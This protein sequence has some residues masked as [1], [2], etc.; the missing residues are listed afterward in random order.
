M[1]T[2]STPPESEP[3]T[4]GL[5]RS[6]ARAAILTGGAAIGAALSRLCLSSLELCLRLAAAV[7][8]AAL[9]WP[10]VDLPFIGRPL[11]AWAASAAV[12][13]RCMSGRV[14]ATGVNE[15]ERPAA[16]LTLFEAQGSPACRKVRECLD[17]LDLDALVYPCP[18]PSNIAY[19]EEMR[20]FMRWIVGGSSGYN[21]AMGGA[22][23]QSR[24]AEAAATAAAAAANGTCASYTVGRKLALPILI[25]GSTTICGAD[26]ICTYLWQMYGQLAKA[27]LNYRI[28]QWLD[29]FAIFRLLPS[30]LRPL[31]RHGLVLSPSVKPEEPLLLWGFE[32]SPFVLRVREALCTLQLP[33]LA[34]HLPLGSVAKRQAFLAQY[35]GLLSAARRAA[36][37]VNGSPLIQVPALLDPNHPEK[38]L[39]LESAAIVRYLYD[40]YGEYAAGAKRRG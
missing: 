16:T 10:Y 33:H 6:L 28:A 34:I 31:P 18:A 27:P 40:T 3:P 5:L 9:D 14:V 24:Y 30:L 19:F 17:V 38:G 35:K 22:A 25:D 1:S 8:G 23:S 26:P 37:Y 21:A 36:P 11:D 13:V 32:S 39:M 2:H 7:L 15:C 4:S 12:L 20:S 29:T